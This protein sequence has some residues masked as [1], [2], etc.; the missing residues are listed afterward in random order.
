MPRQIHIN[1]DGEPK[2]I[3]STARTGDNA[4]KQD[5][6]PGGIAGNVLT[7][8]GTDGTLGSLAVDS[9]PASGSTNLIQSGAVYSAVNNLPSGFTTRVVKTTSGSWTVPKA[10]YYRITCIGG[11]GA[12]AAGGW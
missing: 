3:G 5:K 4:G 9:S 12:G 11:G 10:G 8:S 6:I 7:Y 2:V 1:S